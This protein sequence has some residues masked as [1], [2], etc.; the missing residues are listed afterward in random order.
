MLLRSRTGVIL[1]FV[2]LVLL[3]LGV[4]FQQKKRWTPSAKW[5]P[6]ISKAK[7]SKAAPNCTDGLTWPDLDIVDGPVKYARQQ[8][9]VRPKRNMKRESVTIVHRPLFPELQEIDW[10]ANSEAK[11]SGCQDPIILDVPEFKRREL[12]DASYV[13]FGISTTLQRLEDSIQYLERWIAHTGARLYVIAIAPNE[14]SPDRAKIRDLES[15]MRNLGIHVT[16]SKPLNKKD[17]GSQRYFSLTRLMYSNR[18]EHTK[19]ITLI[20]DDTFFPSMPS[21]MSMLEKYDSKSQ[22]YLGGLSEEWWSVA[23]YGLMAFGGAG[24]F[25]SIALAEV[26]DANYDDCRSHSDTG[27]GD[28]GTHDCISCNFSSVV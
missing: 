11:L 21:L 13:L 23:R 17:V 12:V 10:L 8:I 14:K 6:D 5:V 26:M 7:G 2:T 20:D 4:H 28:V 18:D 19:W 25:L 24:V 3:A 9:I 15:K 16:I 27:S 1:G 22:W